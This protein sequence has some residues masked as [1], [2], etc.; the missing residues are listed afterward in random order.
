MTPFEFA[1]PLALLLLPL[2][3]LP[4]L[5]SRR[6]SLPFPWVGWLPRDR[7]GD[8][9][10][11]LWRLAAVSTMATTVLGLAGPGIREGRVEL[12]GRGAEIAILLDRSSSM[13]AK[14]HRNLLPLGEQPRAAVV[15]EVA[16][17]DRLEPD[18]VALVGEQR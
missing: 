6:D 14:I 18:G 9:V 8:A 12:I 2:A 10:Q 15:E 4:L 5:R 16:L 1:N 3:L 13:D 11:W 7:L 17:V